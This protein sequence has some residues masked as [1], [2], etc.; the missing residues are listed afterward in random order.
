ME[1]GFQ[2]TKIPASPEKS[3]LDKL[4]ISWL[5]ISHDTKIFAES[6]S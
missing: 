4:A 3:A 5:N 1:G 2:A 6:D